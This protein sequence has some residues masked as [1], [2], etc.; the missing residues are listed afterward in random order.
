M[1]NLNEKRKKLKKKNLEKDKCFVEQKL[2]KMPFA[3]T[4]EEK[5][6]ENELLR[7]KIQKNPIKLNKNQKNGPKLKN[8]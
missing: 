4:Q 3:H 6:K 1:K 2:L 7:F 5:S 8:L